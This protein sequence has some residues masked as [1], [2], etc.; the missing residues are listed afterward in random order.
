MLLPPAVARKLRLRVVQLRA[1]SRCCITRN[2]GFLGKFQTKFPDLF[3]L[4][5]RN[6]GFQRDFPNKFP[7]FFQAK[8]P[9]RMTYLNRSTTGTVVFNTTKVKL[10]R[11]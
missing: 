1:V 7:D 2:A 4:R 9:F 10:Y 6:A 3:L 5:T 11:S 8:K